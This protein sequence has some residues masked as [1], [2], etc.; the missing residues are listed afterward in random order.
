MFLTNRWWFEQDEE[1]GKRELGVELRLIKIP[2]THKCILVLRLWCNELEKMYHVKKYSSRKV[3][4]YIFSG[5]MHNVCPFEKSQT[6]IECVWV[7]FSGGK[8]YLKSSPYLDCQRKNLVA[9]QVLSS[10]T[11]F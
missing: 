2:F 3:S 7:K 4:L 6:I 5:S 8:M 1:D 9:K 10:F 11:K